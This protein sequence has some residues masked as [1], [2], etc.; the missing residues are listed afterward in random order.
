MNH[1]VDVHG[2]IENAHENPK[3]LKNKTKRTTELEKENNNLKQTLHLNITFKH[4]R[5]H[6]GR[7]FHRS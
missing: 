4:I 2:Q 7:A 3:L 1:E 6:E 5:I